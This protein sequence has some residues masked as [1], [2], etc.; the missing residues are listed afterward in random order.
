MCPPTGRDLALLRQ[1]DR[2]TDRAI[3]CVRGSVILMNGSEAR[4]RQILDYEF[5]DLLSFRREDGFRDDDRFNRSPGRK[6]VE[7]VS[8]SVRCA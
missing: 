4:I 3:R 6:A 1:F 5:G 8:E 7:A 2:E